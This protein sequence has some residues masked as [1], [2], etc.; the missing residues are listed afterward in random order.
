VN[1]GHE[2]G[3]H[4]FP[5]EQIE[6]LI[7]LMHKLFKQYEIP[8]RNVVGHEDVAPIRKMDPGEL[9]PWKKLV[10]EGLAVPERVRER[11]L[12]T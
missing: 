10:A 4:E 2:L 11:Y 1:K 9:F 5:D 7:K 12:Q 8:L 6:A 3:Y